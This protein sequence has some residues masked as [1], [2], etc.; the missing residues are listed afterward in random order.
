ML[1]LVGYVVYQNILRMHGPLNVK[2]TDISQCWVLNTLL[3]SILPRHTRC[4]QHLSYCGLSKML[5]LPVTFHHSGY[6]S[7][8]CYAE[9][10]LRICHLIFTIV[11][12][13]GGWKLD[14]RVHVG[15]R[16]ISDSLIRTII[17]TVLGSY[18]FRGMY[19]PNFDDTPQ[20]CL[21]H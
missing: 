4:W 9:C 8:S 11:N 14:K 13:G 18:V 12:C 7:V 2:G 20:C 3:C 1:H 15:D 6:T 5:V 16:Y 17:F 10:Y 19:L 21:E